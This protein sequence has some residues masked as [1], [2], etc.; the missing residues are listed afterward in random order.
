MQNRVVQALLWGGVIVGLLDGLD[1]IIF[2]GLRGATPDRIFQAIASGVLG[3]GAFTGGATTVALGLALHFFIACA[4]VTV[5]YL[6]SRRLPSL[7]ARPVLCGA[8]YGVIAYLMMSRV[9]VPLSAVAPSSFSWPVFWNGI[10]I[11]IFG[12][13][14]PSALAARHGARPESSVLGPA[15]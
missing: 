6:A 15:S 2:F 13:G 5:Y 11:H 8:L 10:L 4:I 3:R 9:V 7:A 12:V 1:A 14:I